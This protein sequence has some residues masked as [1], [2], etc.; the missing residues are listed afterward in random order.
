MTW[1]VN[2]ANCAAERRAEGGQAGE[3]RQ[4]SEGVGRDGAW[5][6]HQAPP[7]PSH[8]LRRP[9]LSLQTHQPSCL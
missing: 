4:G 3:A 7:R 8:T 1:R 6:M 5:G 9:D 2:T